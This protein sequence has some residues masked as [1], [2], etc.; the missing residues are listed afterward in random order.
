MD[1]TCIFIKINDV[2]HPSICLFSI[3]LCC[4]VKCLFRSLSI[5]IFGGNC[6]LLWV[7]NCFYIIDRIL[8]SHT[9]FANISTQAFTYLFI[10]L[11]ISITEHKLVIFIKFH[12]FFL[13][14]T[15]WISYLKYLCQI[16]SHKHSFQFFL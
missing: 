7:N 3:K 11:T 16:Q 15:L 4:F 6:F 1:L 9:N 8:L 13:L 10:L 2:E 5:Y 14:R 12:L